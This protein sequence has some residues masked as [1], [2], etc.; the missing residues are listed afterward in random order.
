MA[1]NVNQFITH[2]AQYTFWGMW[3][4]AQTYIRGS[5]QADLVNGAAGSA[6]ALLKGVINVPITVPGAESLDFTGD[7]GSVGTM[8]VKPVGA[9]SAPVTTRINDQNFAAAANSATINASGPYDEQIMSNKGLEF[10]ELCLVV[11][12]P[13]QSSETGSV[14]AGGWDVTELLM[15]T[16]HDVH[17]LNIQSRTPREF[18]KQLTVS[19]RDVRFD[20]SSI[21]VGTY[22]ASQ[23]FLVNYWSAYPVTYVAYV[24]DGGAAQT[25]TLPYTPAAND[26]DAVQVWFNGVAKAYTTHYSVS[27]TTLTFVGTDPAAGVTAVIRMQIAEGQL[28]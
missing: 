4:A 11:N 7:N 22:G 16:A 18:L 24:G 1:D 2:G 14:G 27:G 8:V 6:L 26:G 25:V 15:V 5:S 19:E 12:A 28:G 10:N 23:A 20:G 3:N 13:A 21:V 9:V 17:G